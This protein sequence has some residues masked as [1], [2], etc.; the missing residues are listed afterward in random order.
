MVALVSA[1]VDLRRAG[2]NSYFGRCPFHDERTASFHVSPDEKL[3]HCFGCSESGDPFDF[4]MQTEGLDFKGAL[5]SL[6]DRFGLTLQTEQEDPAAA[7]RR[8]KRERLYALLSRAATF[9][10]RYLWDAHEAAPAREYLLGRGFTEEILREFRVGYAPGAWDHVVQISRKAGYGA[11]DLLA[12]GLAQ[13]KKQRPG[14]LLDRFRERIMFPTADGRGRVR[15]FGARAMHP[16]QRPKYLNTSDSEL[17]HKR[18]VLY[19]IPL[20]RASAAK[21]GRMILVE[22]YTD[23]SAL[24]QAGVR[25]AVGIMGTS[26]TREQVAELVRLVSTVEL[27]LDADRAGQDAMM[28]AAELAADSKLELRV[29]PLPAGA[30]PGDLIAREGA[31][32]LRERVHGSVPFVVFEVERILSVADT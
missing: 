8:A 10:E 25:N 7:E 12:A 19:G 15:G 23:V 1:K 22:G 21:A 3:Y 24:P 11:D 14:E 5:E 27:C 20:A 28:R 31:E 9:Y 4:V 30:D 13:P 18:E 6:A 2:V 17:Y 29:V 26:L 16:D 32:A